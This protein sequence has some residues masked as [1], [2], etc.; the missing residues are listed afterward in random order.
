MIKSVSIIVGT[1]LVLFW[2]LLQNLSL[3]V[4]YKDAAYG[5][6]VKVKSEHHNY[7]CTNLPSKYET[8][9]IK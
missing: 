7:S 8:V 1:V 9:Y 6:C 2:L 5:K 3:P 4:V